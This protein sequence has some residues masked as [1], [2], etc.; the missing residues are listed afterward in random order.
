[1][2]QLSGRCSTSKSMN[3]VG[4]VIG[5]FCRAALANAHGHVQIKALE[6]S[7]ADKAERGDMLTAVS[8]LQA[9]VGQKLDRAESDAALARKLDVRTFLASQSSVPNNLDCLSLTAGGVGG[10]SG[11]PSGTTTATVTHSSPYGT[12]L[13]HAH[14][15]AAHSGTSGNAATANPPQLP[16]A[17][18][19]A[20]APGASPS[21][22]SCGRAA[23]P[24]LSTGIGEHPG[25]STA[26]RG[27]SGASTPT[28]SMH[29]ATGSGSASSGGMQHAGGGI[30]RHNITPAI[31][32]GRPALKSTGSDGGSSYANAVSAAGMGVPGAGVGD[33]NFSESSGRPDGSSSMLR[34]PLA[35]P[36]SGLGGNNMFSSDMTSGPSMFHT[37]HMHGAAGYAGLGGSSGG[38][39]SGALQ[40]LQVAEKWRERPGT[41]SSAQYGSSG[42]HS[43]PLSSQVRVC[44]QPCII[45]MCG[46]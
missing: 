32:M 1:M 31:G 10:P 24:H 44:N 17:I 29:G 39:A 2:V 36:P 45:P 4:G 25:A 14:M 27:A 3:I 20:Y 37:G 15:G 13:S 6:V 28:L 46:M 30:N 42:I 43:T 22:R 9:A 19:D 40:S 38:V 34:P 26:P 7:L 21:A 5:H 33:F 12:P 23:S 41:P 18:N 35:R 16:T 8:S 11:G